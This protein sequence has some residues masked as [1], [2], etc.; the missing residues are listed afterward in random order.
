MA[1]TN[2]T[3]GGFIDVRYKERRE[4]KRRQLIDRR[5]RYWMLAEAR[6]RKQATMLARMR[7]VRAVDILALRS[8][9][10]DK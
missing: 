2:G 10:V 6:V 9:N 7:I 4:V 1:D 3:A 8:R 5:L